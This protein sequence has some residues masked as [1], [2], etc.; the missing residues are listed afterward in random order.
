[1]KLIKRTL[2]TL[3]SMILLTIGLALAEDFSICVV[4]VRT[5]FKTGSDSN[6]GNVFSDLGMG[7][8]MFFEGD[9][10][11]VNMSGDQNGWYHACWNGKFGY[12]LRNC[13]R[14]AMTDD[15]SYRFSIPVTNCD[16][17]ITLRG[18]PSSDFVEVTRIPRGKTIDVYQTQSCW[19]NT[20][21]EGWW[22]V[23][24][25]GE[26]GFVNGRYVCTMDELADALYD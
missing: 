20:S 2:C 3:L 9:V 25:N 8:G 26:F 17:Y 7:E 4:S 5:P 14:T 13:V 11:S 23:K 16:S 21:N 18:G 24:Y 12:V 22:L 19:D 10:L 1:M 6:S 15:L